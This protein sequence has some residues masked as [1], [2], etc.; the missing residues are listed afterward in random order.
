MDINNYDNTQF[1]QVK[2]IDFNLMISAVKDWMNDTK[3]NPTKRNPNIVYLRKDKLLLPQYVSFKKYNEM[4]IRW[5][6]FIATTKVQPGYVVINQP[7][8]TYNSVVGSKSA[9]LVCGQNQSLYQWG[10]FYKVTY[11]N[12][13][14]NCLQIGTLTSPSVSYKKATQEGEITCDENKNGCGSD[15]DIPYGQDKAPR[16][17]FITIIGPPT[18]IQK[19]AIQNGVQPYFVG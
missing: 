7:L 19:R 13:C 18:L 3:R 9:S 4:L 8:L 2:K 17:K 1:Y 14:P 11:A 15:F 5:D 10:D 6:A 12:Q 16:C